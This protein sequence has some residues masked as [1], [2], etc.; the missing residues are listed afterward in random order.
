MIVALT[1]PHNDRQKLLLLYPA[2]DVR[3]TVREFSETLATEV[4][5]YSSAT[6]FFA[7]SIEYVPIAAWCVELSELS[8]SLDYVALHSLLL[9]MAWQNCYQLFDNNNN[10]RRREYYC[11]STYLANI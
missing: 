6:A 5:I 8:M 3:L 7:L 1:F 11:G 10:N 9:S 4:C 2:K